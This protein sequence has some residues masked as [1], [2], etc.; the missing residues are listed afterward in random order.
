MRTTALIQMRGTSAEL[1]PRLPASLA[2]LIP[3]L[4]DSTSWCEPLA[5]ANVEVGPSEL[6][7]LVRFG[8]QR[9]AGRTIL[10]IARLYERYDRAD[11]GDS[12]MAEL[13]NDYS[14][15]PTSD[16]EPP[17][18]ENMTTAF[19]GWW[20]CG[21]CDRVLLEQVGPLK[22]RPSTQPD[23]QLTDERQLLLARRLVPVAERAGAEVRGL[24]GR[25]DFV[26]VVTPD[27]VALR[28]VFPLVRIYEPCPGCGRASYDRIDHVEG[29]LFIDGEDGL[30][31]AKEWPLSA[32]VTDLPASR[33]REPIGWRG[34]P[35][36]FPEGRHEAGTG[37]DLQHDARWRSGRRAV[38]LRLSLVDALLSRGA[39]GL[40][41][42]PLHSMA[43]GS[44]SDSW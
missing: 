7:E 12:P 37:I 33:T 39:T 8:R 14:L 28:P 29:S 30:T 17:E 35:W 26:Q 1:I 11:L 20:E 32:E 40:S 13:N 24:A 27:V 6:A 23:I 41:L 22:V 5:K 25:S 19:R 38:I 15:F 43:P 9:L 31:V 3:V 18:V 42:G 34:G 16:A 2:F 44:P 36:P 21:W 4:R 10:R